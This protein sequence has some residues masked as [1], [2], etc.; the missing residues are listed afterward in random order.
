[1]SSLQVSESTNE[2]AARA[3]MALIQG[4]LS[5]L[6]EQER[7]AYY[8]QVCHSVGLNPNTKPL[9]YLSFQGKLTLYATRNCT[10][11]LRAIHGVSLVSH[12]IKEQNGVLFATVTMRDRNGR[13]D[14]DMGAIPVK[15][16]Q[17]DALA[18]AWMKVLTK[19]KRRCTLSLCG[20]STLDETETDTMPGA[21][22]VEPAA[23]QVLEEKKVDP[24]A[25][26]LVENA[27]ARDK[28][29]AEFTALFNQA[30]GKGN[31][32]DDWKTFVRNQYG[33]TTLKDA[34]IVQLGHLIDWVSGYAHDDQSEAES[35]D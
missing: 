27:K 32:P 14:T 3:N 20:L 5:K 2:L 11:Q 16:L 1:M 13:T 10:D 22:I 23:V 4:D 35:Q 9:G 21:T 12:E 17:G 31:L 6:T 25:E 8:H 30:Q 29:L 33:V 19:A 18:N 28:A 15:N 7:L 26:K 24:K 34:S